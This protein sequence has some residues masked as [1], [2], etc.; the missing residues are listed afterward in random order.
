MFQATLQIKYEVI[1]ESSIWSDVKK[2]EKELFDLYEYSNR[3]YFTDSYIEIRKF[4]DFVVRISKIENCVSLL[5]FTS[6]DDV[7][8]LDSLLNKTLFDFI[9]ENSFSDEVQITQ[10]CFSDAKILKPIAFE[11][12]LNAR[13]HNNLRN[14]R[15]RYKIRCSSKKLFV[16]LVGDDVPNACKI[17]VASLQI[18]KNG[19]MDISCLNIRNVFHALNLFLKL[20]KIVSKSQQK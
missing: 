1:D 15:N 16:I 17:V 3:F 19:D 18:D 4:P 12:F 13:R 8:L 7:L 2:V 20:Y 14:L 5:N 6:P 10:I 9:S 11:P